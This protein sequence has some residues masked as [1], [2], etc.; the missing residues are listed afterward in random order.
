M[1]NLYLPSPKG[2]S[3]QITAASYAIIRARERSSTNVQVRVLA[4]MKRANG[5]QVF[6]GFLPAGTAAATVG[7][8]GQTSPVAANPPSNCICHFFAPRG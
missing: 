4:D 8:G 2:G 3:L 1:L 5:V 7:E 6:W